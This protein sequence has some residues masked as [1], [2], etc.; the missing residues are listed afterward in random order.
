[1]Q[2]SVV[3]GKEK[4]FEQELDRKQDLLPV[5]S[6]SKMMGV[7]ITIGAECE[8][9]GSFASPILRHELLTCQQSKKAFQRLCID[10]ALHS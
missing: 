9:S 2:V 8:V 1:M 4:Y 7:F 3:V 5:Q 6:G 10:S